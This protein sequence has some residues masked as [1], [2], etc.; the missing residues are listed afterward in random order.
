ML[1][2]LRLRQKKWFSKKDV[3]VF[4]GSGVQ[5]KVNRFSEIF[6]SDGGKYYFDLLCIIALF[7]AKEVFFTF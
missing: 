3:F 2:Q 1:S 6:A 4:L 5:V 7:L